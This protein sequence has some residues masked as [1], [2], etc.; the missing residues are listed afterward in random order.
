MDVLT[1]RVMENSSDTSVFRVQA[2][3]GDPFLLAFWLQKGFF[4]NGQVQQTNVLV[5][6]DNSVVEFVLRVLHRCSRL[7][8]DYYLTPF[9]VN[10]CLDALAF[11]YQLPPQP[12]WDGTIRE[13]MN[14]NCLEL[15]R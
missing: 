7:P 15:R 14:G 8:N 4:D 9:L 13:A 2:H 12:D 3:C 6:E 10:L 1:I 11:H 5:H